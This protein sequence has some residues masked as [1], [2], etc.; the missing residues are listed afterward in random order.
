MTI[1]YSA[2]ST[3]FLVRRYSSNCALKGRIALEVVRANHRAKSE[4]LLVHAVSQSPQRRLG[5][6]SRSC[7]ALAQ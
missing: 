5:K 3:R 2:G 1:S 6:A 4:A 7:A